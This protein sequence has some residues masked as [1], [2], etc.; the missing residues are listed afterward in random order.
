M[1][2]RSIRLVYKPFCQS[3]FSIG[4]LTLLIVLFTALPG[5][6]EWQKD[7]ETAMD[8]IKKNQWD[9]AI[10]KLQ[11][12]IKDKSDEGAN[13]KFYGMKFGDYFPHFYLGWAYF[14]LKNYDAA[15]SEFQQSEKFGAIQRKGDL[16]QKMDNMKALSRAQ[17]VA[18]NPQVTPPVV[19][20]PV[21]QVT[22][23]EPP[24]EEKKKEPPP[25][26]KKKE[27]V[28][29]PPV[30]EEKKV[31]D[32]TRVVPETKEPD[33][34]V[35]Q[36]QKPPVVVTPPVDVEA[37][38]TKFAI[39]SGA[40]RYFEGDY[41]GA[42]YLLNTALES[43]SANA[44]AQF[45]L[46]CSY[47]SKYLLSGSQDDEFLRNASTAFQKA[48]QINPSYRVKNRNVFSPAVLALFDKTT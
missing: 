37:E 23:N 45:L 22:K 13:I 36:E 30:V 29:I 3:I 28:L 20:P 8:L 15:L 19:E 18:S 32:A 33:K 17:L 4:A 16:A 31:P 48:K 11:A 42:I 46:G 39:R 7:Y 35:Q 47:A 26:E 6:A 1:R 14:N 44:A 5:F 2:K 41:D 9:A 12:S 40:R 34:P 24:P 10:P 38:N 21:K 25:E 27:P 43:N